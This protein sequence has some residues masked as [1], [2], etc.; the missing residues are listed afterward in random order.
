MKSIIQFN[1]TIYRLDYYYASRA[2]FKTRWEDR[3]VHAQA[4]NDHELMSMTI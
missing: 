1:F 2:S 3:P 4:D